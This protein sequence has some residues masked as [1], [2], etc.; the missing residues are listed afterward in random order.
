[1]WSIEYIL[2]QYIPLSLPSILVQVATLSYCLGVCTKGL[3]RCYKSVC[4]C[5]ASL[6][7][8]CDT[9]RYKA[10]YKL[11]DRTIP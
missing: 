8:E 11:L 2:P 5:S 6:N 7:W 4:H 1:M 3:V 10:L 9:V